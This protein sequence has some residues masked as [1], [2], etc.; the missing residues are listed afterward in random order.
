[1]KPP[2]ISLLKSFLPSI[3]VL[4]TG[5]G[6]GNVVARMIRNG[7]EGV[8]LIACN[9]DAQALEATGA[10]ERILLGEKTTGGRG[11][12]ADA[13]LGRRAAVEAQVELARAV[14]GAEM[15]FIPVGLGGGTGTGAA[16]VVAGLARER[17][18]LT[19]AVATLPFAFEGKRRMATALSGLADLRRRCDVVL[20]VPNDRLVAL[21]PRSTS[22]IDAFEAADGVLVDVIQ[23][24]ADLVTHAGLINVDLSDVRTIMEERGGAVIG[25]ATATGA[26]RLVE[27]VDKA[28]SNPL[29]GE[30]DI[31]GAKGVLAHVM[32]DPQLGLIEVQ[33]AMERIHRLAGGDANFIFGATTRESMGDAVGVVVIVTGL[34]NTEPWA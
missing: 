12:G 3:K 16:P 11:A 25:K 5:G 32:G 31:R 14:E 21:L 6:G 7:I 27:A 4:G 23:G 1:M 17:G 28:I 8:D 2:G 13:T 22:L 18:A 15:V 9:T 10:P 20:V 24:I 34:A 19:V 26:N 30:V 33:E 29:M